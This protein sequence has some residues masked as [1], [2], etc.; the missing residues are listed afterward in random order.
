M[1]HYVWKKA[2]FP[3]INTHRLCW[4]WVNIAPLL[5]GNSTRITTDAAAEVDKK[6]ELSHLDA[7]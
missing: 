4:A 3:L 5:A 6:T 2:C 1:E 7:P